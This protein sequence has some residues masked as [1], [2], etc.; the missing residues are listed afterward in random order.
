MAKHIAMKS[1]DDD[2]DG[3]YVID[4]IGFDHLYSRGK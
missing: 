4:S 2:C 1:Q 3:G